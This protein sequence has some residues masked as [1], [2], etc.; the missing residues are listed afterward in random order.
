MGRAFAVLDTLGG[1]GFAIA[2]LAAGAAIAGLGIRAMFAIAG[3]LG[4]AI[5]VAAWAAF[6]NVWTAPAGQPAEAPD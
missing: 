1:W 3:G 2:F 6:R 4:I 5:W